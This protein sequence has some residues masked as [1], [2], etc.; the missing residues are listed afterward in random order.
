[1]GFCLF[2]MLIKQNN[3]WAIKI[4]SLN[5]ILRVNSN[6]LRAKYEKRKDHQSWKDKTEK[7]DITISGTWNHPEFERFDV[8]L[9]LWLHKYCSKIKD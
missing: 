8:D 7:S 3:E 2:H 1:M 4:L 6:L 5:N 9:R